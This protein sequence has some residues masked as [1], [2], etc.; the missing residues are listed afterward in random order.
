MSTLL[1]TIANRFIKAESLV[2]HK[3]T[4]ALLDDV[5]NYIP[6]HMIECGNSG[7][8]VMVTA[9]VSS[10]D[11]ATFVIKARSAYVASAKKIIQKVQLTQSGLLKQLTCV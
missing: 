11:V 7:R 6:V 5:S 9:S 10:V 2:G 1:Q 8:E 4:E 3:I